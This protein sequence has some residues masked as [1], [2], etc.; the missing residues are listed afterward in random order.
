MSARRPPR[1]AIRPGDRV[2]VDDGEHTVLGWSG[3]TVRLLDDAGEQTMTLLAHLLGAP[4]F[5]VLAAT[6]PVGLAG[7][8]AL[9]D[10][11][12]EAATRARW[13][14]RHIVEV[15]TG[16]PPGAAADAVG[17]P[18]YDPAQHRLA[19]R[20]R[21]KAA[22]LTAAG[23]ACSAATVRRRRYAY[24]ASGLL[25]LVDRRVLRTTSLTG[26]GTSAWSRQCATP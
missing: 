21:A 17:R 1:P 26:R 9:T 25:G 14:E 22:E 2:V 24:A 11:G 7:L 12:E 8:S 6:A 16:H 20:E 18:A 3:T 10:V 5:R 4:G 19:E 23:F 15:Q 13:W